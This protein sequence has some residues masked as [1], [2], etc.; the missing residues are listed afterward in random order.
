[1]K[2]WRSKQA[3]YTLSRRMISEGENVM[4]GPSMRK[5]NQKALGLVQ[6]TMQYMN[7]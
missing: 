5:A 7:A 1:M 3:L 2:H 6:D 4:Y